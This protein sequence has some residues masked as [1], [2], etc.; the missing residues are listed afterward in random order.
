MLVKPDGPT[1]AKIMIVGEAPG[2]REEQLGRPFVGASGYELDRMLNEAGISRSE[3][4]VTN[5]VRVRPPKNEIQAFFAKAKKDRTA[6]HTEFKG[7][8]VTREVLEGYDLLKS[9]IKVVNPSIIIALG[10]TPLWALTDLW[11]ITKWRGSML[12]TNAAADPPVK[13]IPTIHPASVLREWKQRSIVV[14]DLRRA[15]RFRNDEAYPKPDWKFIIRPDY[16]TV[17]LTL[18]RL[19][20]RSHHGEPLVI[21]FD[22]ETKKGHI[23]CAGLAWSLTEALCIPLMA[24]GKP[25]GYWNL[26]QEAEIVWRLWRLLTSP[27]VEVVGQNIIYDSQY[28]WKH[29]HFVPRVTQDTMIS[30]HS[31]FADL[32][33]GLG[34]LASMYCNYYVY[35]KDE[36]KDWEAKDGGEDAWW[37]Y[38]C[39]DTVYTLE[40]A[41][42]LKRVAAKLGLEAVHDAQQRMFWPVLAAM[43]RGVRIDTKRRNELILEVQ[44]AI[45]QREG[46][47]N[48]VVGFP[49]NYDSPKQMHAFFYDDLKL[50]IQMTRAK[51]GAPAR[52]TLDDDALQKL[53]RIEPLVS[54]IVNAIADC[55]TL[56]KFLSNFL[57]RP[58]SEDGRMRCSFR[59]GGS[60]SG[61]SAPKTYRLSSAED[62]FGCGTNLQTI[63]SRSS[64]SLGKA[65]ARGG[66]AGLGDPYH[67]PNLREI[68]IPDPGYTWLELDLERADLFVVCWEAGDEAL[69]RAMKAGVDI[70]LLN[71]FVLTGKEPPP[72]EHLIERHSKEEK[73]TCPEVCYWKIREPLEHSRQ[74]A[75]VFCHGTNYGG[76]PRTMSAHTGRSIAEVERAQRLWFGAHPSIERGH[77]SVQQTVAARRFVENRFGYRW[78]IF[79][80]PDSILPEAIAWFP[81]STVSIVIN[82]IWQ[83]IFDELPEVEVLIQVHDSLCMQVPTRRLAVLL[84]KIR[85]CAKVT[86]PYPDPLIIPVSI[87]MSER[88]WGH[89]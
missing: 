74:F 66:V 49:V 85:E 53:A 62:A 5:L 46:F 56:G 30:Q 12:Y 27:N 9:E 87:K 37:Y 16:E 88:S 33:K 19:Y 23:A 50:P 60:E 54:P 75:K 14:N 76:K 44:D 70:H 20:I 45:A 69:K 81:Q 11:G 29:W 67:F 65:A 18:D 84:P 31:V 57:C 36:G 68:F 89:C 7:K 55:R 17:I 32:S 40:V 4:F 72:Y 2:E 52:P 78:Y 80:R 61:A 25:Q 39:E 38:N 86:I 48:E 43:K 24:V 22:I 83:R 58:L 47:L 73:C 13:V 26:E 77:N 41:H 6:A 71:A 42:A 64:K 28:T 63:P 10:N 8:W 15:G 51:K 34:F 82:R 1:N 79:D 35:W 59:I 21:S 3:C